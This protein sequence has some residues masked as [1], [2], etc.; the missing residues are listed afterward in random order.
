M[1]LNWKAFK[2]TYFSLPHMCHHVH[3]FVYHYSYHLIHVF[4]L[5]IY[6]FTLLSTNIMFHDEGAFTILV[7]VF[8]SFGSCQNEYLDL[9]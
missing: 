7:D 6:V 8:N 4:D 5:L 2:T 3:L 9:T 1:K